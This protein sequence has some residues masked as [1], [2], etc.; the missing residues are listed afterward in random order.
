MIDLKTEE[1]LSLAQAAARLPRGRGNRPVHFSTILRWIL[2]G[3]RGPAGE[4]V[5]LEGI[6]LG[7]RW[8]TSAEALQRFA[9]A[10]T[11]QSATVSAPRS[12]LRR[13]AAARRAGERLSA[14]GI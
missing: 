13:E 8:L 10:L 12:P 3:V 11:P 7:D 4:K 1:M 2:A 6:R 5:K 14:V 9:E